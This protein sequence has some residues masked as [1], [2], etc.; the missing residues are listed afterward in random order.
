MIHLMLLFAIFSAAAHSK[1][2]NHQEALDDCKIAIQHDP[3]Y[4]KAY[5]RMG[6]AYGNLNDHQRAR[7]SYKK[8]FELDPSEN[9]QNNLKLAEQRLQVR[10]LV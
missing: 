4:S 1:L 3:N 7:D 5:C 2:G 10:F 6:L 9:N 8:A